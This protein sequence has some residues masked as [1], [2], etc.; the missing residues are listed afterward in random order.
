MSWDFSY[1]P[2]L[3]IRPSEMR[4]LEYL[5]KVAKNKLCPCFLL[6]PWVNATNLEAAI[7][8][9]ERVFPNRPYFLDIENNYFPTNPERHAVLEFEALKDGR[10]A[11][12]NWREFVKSHENVWP[13]IQAKTRL[14]MN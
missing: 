9:I 1:V 10:N 8:K 5:P 4:G 3:A 13:C 2:T 14:S 6:A 12:E 7:Q 11:F